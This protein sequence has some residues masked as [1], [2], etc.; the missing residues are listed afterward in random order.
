MTKS[1]VSDSITKRHWS[2]AFVYILQRALIGPSAPAGFY[3]YIV[4][5]RGDDSRTSRTRLQ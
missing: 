2:N 5:K 3:V 1:S 4:I